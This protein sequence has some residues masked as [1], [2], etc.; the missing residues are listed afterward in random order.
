MQRSYYYIQ[1]FT[2]LVGIILFPFIAYYYPSDK[3]EIEHLPTI[4]IIYY[5]GFIGYTIITTALYYLLNKLI[6]HVRSIKPLD[7]KIVFKP[8]PYQLVCYGLVLT[9]SYIYW[10]AI[11]NI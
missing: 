9:A 11:Y 6:S 8:I 3:I 2:V 7:R 10:Y 5:S 4:C 1:Y